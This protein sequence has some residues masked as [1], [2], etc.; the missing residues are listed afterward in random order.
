[1]RRAFLLLLLVSCTEPGGHAPV[2][3]I[4]ALPRALPEHDNYQTD[5]VLDGR[6]SADPLDDPDGTAPLA[7]IWEITNDDY[8]VFEGDEDEAVLTVR[9]LGTRPPSV[10][11][12]VMDEDGQQSTARLQ[13]Q[14]TLAP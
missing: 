3:R 1:V 12:T 11:L 10:R 6:A 7:Y 13:L 4:D 5:I 8:E 9:F 14:L 2:A